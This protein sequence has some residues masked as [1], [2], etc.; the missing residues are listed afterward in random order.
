MM[1]SPN[2][3]VTSAPPTAGGGATGGE[4][5]ANPEDMKRMLTEVIGR[6]RQ[7]ASEN[8]ID[9]QELIAGAEGNAASP[10]TPAPTAPP[11]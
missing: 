8:G 4:A 2:L 9:F 10:V 11:M 6:V 5:K 7:I 1:P 3:P